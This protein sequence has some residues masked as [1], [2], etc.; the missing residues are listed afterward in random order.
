MWGKTGSPF[1]G[2][3]A[4]AFGPQP[5]MHWHLLTQQ[6]GEGPQTALGSAKSHRSR[7]KSAPAMA[8]GRSNCTSN[9]VC[10]GLPPPRKI[11]APRNCDLS[12]TIS[13][14]TTGVGEN[15][16]AP[17]GGHG[18]PFPNP[19]PPFLARRDG[20]MTTGIHSPPVPPLP[21]TVVVFM[22]GLFRL[23]PRT[24]GIRI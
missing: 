8:V 16:L 4:C 7:H 24:P 5:H 13:H 1:W 17:T 6:D 9:R 15:W 21:P 14:T 23:H 19:P 10:R 3:W 22:S 11:D 18:C 12:D 20:A 2:R